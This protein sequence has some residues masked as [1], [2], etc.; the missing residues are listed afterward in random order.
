MLA[1]VRNHPPKERRRKAQGDLMR[2]EVNRRHLKDMQKEIN[3]PVAQGQLE[4]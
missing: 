4:V 1:G 3:D 2:E